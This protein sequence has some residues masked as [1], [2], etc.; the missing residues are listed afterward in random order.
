M[1]KHLMTKEAIIRLMLRHP[2]WTTDDL[3]AELI[4]LDFPEPTR[5]L[6][7][8]YRDNFNTVLKCLRAEGYVIDTPPGKPPHPDLIRK[9][10]RKRK[11]KPEPETLPFRHWAVGSSDKW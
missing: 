9:P 6:V 1:A 10:K 3:L 8:S 2:D 11:P 5:L 4:A 7:R